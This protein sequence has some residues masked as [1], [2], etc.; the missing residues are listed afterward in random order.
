MNFCVRPVTTLTGGEYM[1][2]GKIKWFNNKKGFGFIAGDNG[3]DIFV[4][5]SAI[6]QDGYKTLNT[7]DQVEYDLVKSEKGDQ[8]QNVRKVEA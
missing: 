3:K 2:T 5:F 1:V 8:A 4:H 6:Q 7:D